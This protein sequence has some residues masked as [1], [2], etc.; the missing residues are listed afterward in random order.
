MTCSSISYAIVPATQMHST[1]RSRSAL[2]EA[3]INIAIAFDCERSKIPTRLSVLSRTPCTL[4]PH[5]K[6]VGVA[7]HFE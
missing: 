3:R 1:Y 5:R 6:V 4:V 2:I 7:F